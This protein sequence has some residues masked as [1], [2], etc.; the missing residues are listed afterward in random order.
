MT[1]TFLHNFDPP[2]FSPVTG[3]TVDRKKVSF[4]LLLRFPKE[5]TAKTRHTRVTCLELGARPW[6]QERL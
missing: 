3:A 4:T 5:R 2:A 6:D 1:R